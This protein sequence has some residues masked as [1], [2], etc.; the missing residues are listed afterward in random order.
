MRL[1]IFHKTRLCFKR[2]Y[3]EVPFKR[4]LWCCKVAQTK[5][6][7]DRIFLEKG[8]ITRKLIDPFDREKTLEKQIIYLLN[9]YATLW[10]VKI[11]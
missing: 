7:H 9:P 8:G 10:D 4:F 11:E 6:N 2:C 5:K 1:K 3:R